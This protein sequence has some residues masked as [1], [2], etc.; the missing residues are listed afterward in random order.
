MLLSEVRE[1]LGIQ[2]PLAWVPGYFGAA[3]I[4]V[5]RRLRW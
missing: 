1:H 5:Y 4:E 3:A 2:I